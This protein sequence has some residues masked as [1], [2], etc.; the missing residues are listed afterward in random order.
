VTVDGVPLPVRPGLVYYLLYKPPGVVSTAHD[1]Q[2]RPTVIGLVPESPRV[3]PVGRLDADSEGLLLVTNDG[4]LTARLTHPRFGVRKTYVAEVRG[5][6]LRSELRRL[7][8]GVELE[9][10]PARATAA[11]LLEAVSGRALVEI[12]MTEGRKREVRRLLDA[13]GFPVVRLTRVAVGTVRDR[14]LRPGTWRELTVHEIRSLYDESWAAWE[15]G[16]DD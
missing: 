2:G 8:E 13:V 16:P 5:T 1:P 10:G 3:Y 4:D 12:V 14:S 9:D 15:D 11:R 6:P 7:T